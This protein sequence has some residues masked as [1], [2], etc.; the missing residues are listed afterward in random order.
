MPTL[1]Q[2]KFVGEANDLLG[3]SAADQLDRLRDIVCLQ[4][5]DAGVEVLDVL[6]HDDH[7]DPFALVAG[8]HAREFACRSN[9]GVR[10]KKFAQRDVGALLTE[11]DRC[12]EWP[13]QGNAGALNAVACCGRDARGVAL[14]EDLGTRLSL[15]PVEGHA[16]RCGGGVEDALRGEGDL[17]ANPVAR[18]QGDGVA[19]WG[20]HALRIAGLAIGVTPLRRGLGR[21]AGANHGR[22][23]RSRGQWRNPSWRPVTRRVS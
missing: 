9:V 17:G 7:V 18:D 20:G 8:W 10:L 11:A 19:S 21:S 3:A 5:L 13:L 2:S 16:R 23:C 14:L 22:Q 12:L 6:A 15:L 1:A 4:M